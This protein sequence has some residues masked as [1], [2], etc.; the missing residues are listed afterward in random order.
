MKEKYQLSK[1]DKYLISIEKNIII[2]LLNYLKERILKTKKE[3]LTMNELE[4]LIDDE[5]FRNLEIANCNLQGGSH[6]LR[7]LDS[8]FEN[9][10]PK[11]QK[12]WDN[13]L[14]FPSKELINEINE[15]LKFMKNKFE[16][17]EYKIWEDYN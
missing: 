12:S 11:L 9:D 15:S 2:I 13:D 1:I 16:K 14:P 4:E 5:S 3:G 17:E 10:N 6:Y 8:I 7:I